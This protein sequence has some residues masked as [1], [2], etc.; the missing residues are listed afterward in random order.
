[1]GDRLSIKGVTLMPFC[2]HIRPVLAGLALS[3]TWAVTARGFDSLY[4]N[5]LLVLV[6]G[7][8]IDSMATS[9]VH[10]SMQEVPLD[11][12]DRIEVI[13]GLGAARWGATAMNGVINII[14][15]PARM[16]QDGTVLLSAGSSDRGS[17][18]A[19][20]GGRVGDAGIFG[21][22]VAAE[23]TGYTRLDARL[24]R[25]RGPLGFS[26]AGDNLPHAD[27]R[28]FDC[29]DARISSRIPRRATA[30]IT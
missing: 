19:R 12:I 6:D 18:A 23:A 13:R 28:A 20:S 30:R 7:R 22:V 24:G 4:S 15:K 29:I 26:V 14:T 27:D 5:K 9:G 17:A 16:T 11:E 21:E 10:W 3:G 8:S 1:M 25:G 2:A